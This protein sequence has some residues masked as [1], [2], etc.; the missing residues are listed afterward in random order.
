MLQYFRNIMLKKKRK[1]KSPKT[2][3]QIIYIKQTE[4]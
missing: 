4:M 2:Q 1:K 3:L